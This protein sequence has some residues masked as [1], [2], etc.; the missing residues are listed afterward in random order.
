[1]D[2]LFGGIMKTNWYTPCPLVGNPCILYMMMFYL[3]PIPPSQSREYKCFYLF[4]ILKVLFYFVCMKCFGFCFVF[5]ISMYHAHVWYHIKP[6]QGIGSSRSLVVGDFLWTLM[7]V[8][9]KEPRSSAKK[10]KTLNTKPFS[11][12]LDISI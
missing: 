4:I 1:M 2:I 7:W 9:R 12:T 8:L 5:F 11:Q 10:A 6:S 3:L